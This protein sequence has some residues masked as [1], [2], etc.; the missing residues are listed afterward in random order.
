MFS[1]M[2]EGESG[3]SRALAEQIES[4]R[5][6]ARQKR[7]QAGLPPLPADEQQQPRAKKGKKPGG[8]RSKKHGQFMATL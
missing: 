5:E 8:K 2:A 6:D 4:A 1:V 7:E 3:G